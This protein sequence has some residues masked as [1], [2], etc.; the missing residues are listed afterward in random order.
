MHIIETSEAF[1]AAL[2]AGETEC[3][4]PPFG[5]VYMGAGYIKAMMD[6]TARRHPD[7]PFTLWADCG[8]QPGAA[9]AAMRVGLTHLTLDAPPEVMAKLADMAAQSGVVI[10]A[11]PGMT[12]AA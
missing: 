5:C 2:A 7:T 8:D 11:P 9:M 12:D 1:Y 4:T 10:K 6:E 3:A